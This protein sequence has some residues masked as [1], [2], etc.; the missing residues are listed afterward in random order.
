[1]NHKTPLRILLDT[2][3]WRKIFFSKSPLASSLINSLKLHKAKI[4]FPEI[5]ELELK[6][7]LLR[8]GLDYRLR[9]ENANK[10]LSSLVGSEYALSIPTDDDIKDSI[11]KRLEFLKEYLEPIPIN[12]DHVKSAIKRIIDK[13]PP[14]SQNKEQ[15]RDSFI[16]EVGLDLANKYSV[17]FVSE[18]GDFF[19]DKKS[20]TFHKSLLDEIQKGG[21]SLKPFSSLAGCLK[22]LMGL[23]TINNMDK[24]PGLILEFIKKDIESTSNRQEFNVLE[25]K[26]FK[27]VTL[28]M[29]K[30]NHIALDFTIWL[31]AENLSNEERNSPTAE[32]KGVGDANIEDNTLSDVEL[33]YIKFIW[34]DQA[35]QQRVQTNYYVRPA[36]GI[37]MVQTP[38]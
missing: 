2:N 20:K 10:N 23:A 32:I 6:R 3:I 12:I 36:T 15:F 17:Y 37:Y 26:S 34:N 1:M 11:N 24:I 29:T 4:L 28:Q 35:G 7:I 25:V 19:S 22:E 38:K 18:D 9:I 30:P 33:E 14:N 21:I 16:W 27:L 8:D 13:I 31:D 5:I